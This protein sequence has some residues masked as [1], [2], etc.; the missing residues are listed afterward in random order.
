[1]AKPN[2][3]RFLNAVTK[4]FGEGFVTFA[5]D[6]KGKIERLA[7]GI[8]PLD[9]HILGGLPMGKLSL[10]RGPESGTK[11]THAVLACA[12]YLERYK[13][14]LA[15]F[16]DVE[17]KYP[18]QLG[19]RLG[20]DG[21]RFLR[22]DPET[23]EATIDFVEHVLREKTVGILVIDSV[24]AIIPRIEIEASAED[25]QQ[26]LAARMINKM[27]RKI[28]SA[29]KTARRTRGWAPTVILVNQERFRVGVKFGDPLTIPGGEGQKFAA[30]L[31]LRFRSMAAKKTDPEYAG[32]DTPLVK[33]GAM[34][35]KHS[36]GPKGKGSEYYLALDKF[37]DLKTGEA[38]DQ[39][40][41]SIMARKLGYV[42]Q[43]G[44][45]FT[46]LGKNY[47]TLEI[48]EKEMWRREDT[49]EKLK[50]KII[51]G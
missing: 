33:V 9:F 27:I 43:N 49:Y 1:M 29:L 36:F 2:K 18:A 14:R 17:E 3:K 30:S 42:G 26:A 32:E 41:V 39:E 4:K 44:K 15:V 21:G 45:G 37:A 25:Q 50:A 51:G 46:C 38:I 10:F 22:A 11:T 40:F 13:D 34:V 19:E 24:A 48:F 12:R 16:V 8:A 23:A 31:I 7:L 47:G 35:L 28:I 6:E 20:V 5:E